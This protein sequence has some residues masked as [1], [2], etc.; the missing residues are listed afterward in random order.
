MH[1]RHRKHTIRNV[2][3]IILAFL[4]LGTAAYS[5]THYRS[6]KAAI[7]SSFAPSGVNKDRNTSSILEKKTPV[8]ILL[9]GTQDD[10]SGRNYSGKTDSMMVVTINPESR[11]T[12]IVNID[13]DTSIVVPGFEDKSPATIGTAY[14][15][16]S[17]KTAITSVEKLLNVPI[18]FYAVVNM[19][20][21]DQVID[22]MNGIDITPSSSFKYQGY[23]FTKGKRVHM[24]SQK[25]LAYSRRDKD[26]AVH[27]FEILSAILRH[28][29]SLVSLM[30]Q[31]FYNSL[32]KQTQTD[33]TFDD[34]RALTKNFIDN[35]NQISKMQLKGKTATVA[36][37]KMEIV[38]KSDLQDVTDFL[39]NSLNLREKKTG[40]IA[41]KSG[42][43]IKSTKKTKK[44]KS[45]KKSDKKKSEKKDETDTTDTTADSNDTT[46]T[47][48]TTNNSTNT[49]AG[50]NS[51]SGTTS[52]NSGTTSSNSN[53]YSGSSSGSTGSTWRPSNSGSNSSYTGNSGSGSSSNNY[54][55]GGSSSGSSSSTGSNSGSG[56]GSSTETGGETSEGTSSGEESGSIGN[57]YDYSE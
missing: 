4:V 37:Q 50:T 53:S 31:D 1:N 2:F 30:N 19:N 39:R 27:Q 11:K 7:N 24:D 16:G 17:A 51:N 32:A 15:F 8:S 45:K 52:A 23:T 14:S 43:E 3:L 48:N 42:E 46:A 20:G 40:S 36:K 44:K 12:S 49:T 55:G 54:Y 34:F 10:K 26:S 33:L 35:D 47:D 22:S 5:M 6:V 57:G 21:L 13:S 18:D 41:Y 9:M 29:D 38:D 28:G 56:A 25:A